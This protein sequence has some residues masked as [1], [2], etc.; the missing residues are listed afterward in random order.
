MA[1]PSDLSQLTLQQKVALGSGADMWRTRAV[2]AIGTLTLVD[3]PHGVRMPTARSAGNLDAAATQ[4]ATCFPPAVALAQTWDPAL[5]ERVGV[6]LGNEC[7]ALGV[8]VLLGPGLNIKRDPRA[9]RNF[10][11][12]SEDPLLT[13]AL[14]T[15]WVA[16]LQSTGVGASVKHFA[17][18][19][20][21]TDRMRASSDVD[22]RT[23]R[24]IYLRAFQAVV[25]RAH[26]WT[27]MCSYN[28][29]NGVYASQ[30][31]W[32]LTDVLREEWGYDGVVV[33]DWGAVSDRVAAVAA[34]LDLEM[35]GAGDAG[36][37]A[38]LAAVDAGALSTS[39]V[40]RA[41]RRVARLS[42]RVAQR[43]P[44]AEFDSAA[45]HALARE[46]AGRAVVLLKNDD[47][48]LPLDDENIAVIGEFA[49]APVYQ[50]GGSSH[51]RPTRLDVPIE[52]IR[53]LA[54]DRTVSYAPGFTAGGDGSAALREEAVRQATAAD[55]AVVFLGLPPSA[56][57]EGWD[58]EH[59]DLPV[60]Q[61]DLLRAVAEAQPRTV[62]VLSH[63]GVVRSGQVAELAGAI[64]DG[65]LLGQ[66]GG[67]AIADVLFGQVNPSGR[68]AETVPLRLD[69]APSYLNFPG[70]AG[71]V[72]YG[73]RVFVGYRG[74]DAVGRD[75]AYPFGHGL[76]YTEFEYADLSVQVSGGDDVTVRLTV[77]NIGRRSG[78]EVVQVYAG[79]PASAVPRPPRWL[80]SFGDVQL[81]AGE[82]ATCELLFATSELAYWHT[83]A[84]RWAIEGGEYAVSVGASSRDLR[85]T[86]TVTV[87]GDEP[88]AVLTLESTLAE[89]LSD[90]HAGPAVI[91]ALSNMGGDV[92]ST[93][94]LGADLLKIM[95]GIPIGRF[96]A[97]TGGKISAEEIR[98]LLE[99]GQP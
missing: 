34:G 69:D 68:L 14:G 74:Y 66:A 67:G 32:L 90:P 82:T 30:N 72:C 6:A 78:R 5:I 40:D 87:S 88:R 91:S 42:A 77:T 94:D 63:G 22:A 59:I 12:F 46:V 10:E 76:S 80:V 9:G 70:E 62:A 33:S 45:H 47:D 96:I 93:L 1:D 17:A 89:V 61:L 55:V 24:E 29:I 99:S 56:E 3:G 31:R 85:L 35:P 38:V 18:N 79:L 36:D 4:P 54:G 57:S 84:G 8:D 98:S 95:G 92:T 21:E 52:E 58:R 86:G 71:H 97:F 73:E 37:T 50:G 83:G 28:R 15:A 48:L 60:E 39:D 51:V 16:G 13:A 53:R 7:R 19:N 81:D 26:P 44:A 41:A 23:L 65:A 43:A 20:T 64:L 25:Q 11:Y 2:G 75:V 27:V 49:Q